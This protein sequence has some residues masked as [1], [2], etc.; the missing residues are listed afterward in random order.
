MNPGEDLNAML[1]LTRTAPAADP[2]YL[3]SLNRLD[4]WK[5]QW[6]EER[7]RNREGHTHISTVQ[8]EFHSTEGSNRSY[9]GDSSHYYQTLESSKH[10]EDHENV[11]P[12]AAGTSSSSA[13]SMERILK[14]EQLG[15]SMA[16]FVLEYVFTHELG[17]RANAARGDEGMFCPPPGRILAERA[18]L[19]PL[20]RDDIK[21]G[22]TSSVG[23]SSL[24]NHDHCFMRPTILRRPLSDNVFRYRQSLV[25]F[26][27]LRDTLGGVTGPH[28]SSLRK[29]DAAQIES[30]LE[31]RQWTDIEEGKARNF[32]RNE[33]STPAKSISG[34]ISAP[35]PSL[36]DGSITKSSSVQSPSLQLFQKDKNK[37]HNDTTHLGSNN[38]VDEFSLDA[39]LN[40]SDSD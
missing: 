2:L 34:F 14:A 32:S 31:G 38:E 11:S 12:A 21:Y 7:A 4:P 5:H 23:S 25:I 20:A 13:E 19:R 16:H 9:L 37:E 35:V 39:Y 18:Q 30:G 15:S 27:F 40:G 10:A 28:A 8:K 6:K 29:R 22:I 36:A 3:P 1:R 26:D 24:F 33:E 17:G